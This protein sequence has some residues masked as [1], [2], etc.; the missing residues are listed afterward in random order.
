MAQGAIQAP[1]VI[2]VPVEPPGAV[3]GAGAADLDAYLGADA[4]GVI[5]TAEMTGRAGEVSQSVAGVGSRASRVVFLGVGDRSPGALRKA[6][7]ALGRQ[8]PAGRSAVTTV[9]LDEPD[10]GMHAF[11]DKRQPRYEGH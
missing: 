1:A 4:A 8:V 9:V 11:V 5:A 6:G 7:G 3:P 2:A 10:E